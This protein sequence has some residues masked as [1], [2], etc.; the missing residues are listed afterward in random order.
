MIN[1]LIIA[2][3]GAGKTTTLIS[4]AIAKSNEGESVLIT[5]FTEACEEEIRAKLIEECGGFT[6]TNITIQ[7]WFSFLIKHGAKPYQDCVISSEITGLILVSGLSG[8]RFT[9][10]E[11][12]P[13]YWSEDKNIHEHYLSS[14]G[15]IYSD[16]LAK[17][18]ARCNKDSNGKV[19]SRISECFDNIFIDE[20]QDLAG[21][22][23]EI[24]KELFK[25][26]SSILLVGDPRQ[27]TYSTNNAQ[28]NSKFK[29]SK[30]VNFFSSNVNDL[31]ID[32]KSLTKNYRCSPMICDYSN[33]LYPD[34]PDVTSGNNITTGHDGIIIVDKSFVDSYLR[35]FNPVQLRYSKTTA[36]NPNY[37]VHTYGKS[38]GL[39]FDRSLIYPTVPIVKWLIDSESELKTRSGFYV[40]LTRAK[41][42]VAIVL[43]PKQYKN[44]LDFPIY[45]G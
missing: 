38:K 8:V 19:I 13:V 30:I 4:K 32:D 21:Y 43:D 3:A 26:K 31:V 28:K 15:K 6:P 10:K 34:L 16:K 22:D 14:T 5:T 24:L 17:F 29:K 36:V 39:T 2:S 42:S 12:R 11:G 35:E 20:V 33:K 27:A 18:V 44:L 7:T 9:T 40:A 37:P 23:L 1:E 41:Y 45:K 25:C